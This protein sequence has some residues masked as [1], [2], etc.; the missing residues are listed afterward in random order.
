MAAVGQATGEPVGYV[1]RD[2]LGRVHRVYRVRA[3]SAGSGH[4]W[5]HYGRR[6][7]LC[8]VD[9]RTPI[10]RGEMVQEPIYEPFIL[11]WIVGRRAEV[12][13]GE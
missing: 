13:R 10:P 9:Y 6:E 11:D 3:V 8:K 7:L 2:A 1:E 5:D 12:A 4:G